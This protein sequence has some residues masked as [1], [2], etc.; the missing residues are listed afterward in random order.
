MQ[1]DWIN[2][3]RYNDA[4]KGDDLDTYYNMFDSMDSDVVVGLLRSF[5]ITGSKEAGIK[6]ITFLDKMLI[7][8]IQDI[9]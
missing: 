7:N 6:L 5:H 8:H 3:E 9:E 1:L 2:T 4:L